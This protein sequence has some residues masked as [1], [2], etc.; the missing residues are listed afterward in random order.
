VLLP[1][2]YEF[3][4]QHYKISSVLVTWVKDTYLSTILS[5]S[6]RK[7]LG[8]TSG[9]TELVGHVVGSKVVAVESST[10]RWLCSTTSSC[11]T[12]GKLGT[13]REEGWV[14]KEIESSG[15]TTVFVGVSRALVTTARVGKKGGVGSAVPQD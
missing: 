7:V 9:G 5:A 1:V 13:R 6:D 11:P 4:H 10:A 14:G 8:G 3:P 2:L 15:T 12:R